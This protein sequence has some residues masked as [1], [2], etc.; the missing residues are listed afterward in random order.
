MIKLF[1]GCT[2]IISS[3]IILCTGFLI[4]A[5]KSVDRSADINSGAFRYSIFNID[6]WW[7]V[8]PVLLLIIGF[9][10]IYSYSKDAEL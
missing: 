9:W 10:L 1:L 2:S 8:I 3:V 4:S 7:F 6:L 5:L